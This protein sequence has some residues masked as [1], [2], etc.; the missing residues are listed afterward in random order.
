[1]NVGKSVKFSKNGLLTTLSC[2]YDNK[3]QYALEGSVFIAG[4]A[5]QWLRDSLKIIDKASDT[6][7]YH[8]IYQTLKMF[9]LFLL[10]QDWAHLIGT[11][12]QEELFLD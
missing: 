12:I 3:P 8:K 7:K 10:L 9:M 11:C 1:M 4:A 6:E 5:I 2:S